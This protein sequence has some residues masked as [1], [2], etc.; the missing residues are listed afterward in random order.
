[1]A[2]TK[3]F[4]SWLKIGIFSLG[5]LLGLS[6]VALV[7][8]RLVTG[9]G[10]G[11]L[12]F[13][14]G[15][16]S[17]LKATLHSQDATQLNHG[18]FTNIVFLHHSTGENLIVQGS[19]RERFTQA[20]YSFWDQGYN[21]AGLRA[22]D[23]ASTGY[24]YSVPN[25]NTDP[26]SLARIFSQ[27]VYNYPINALSGL[28]QHEVI[29]IKSCFAPANNIRS[30]SQLEDFKSWYTGIRHVM[31]QHP[32]KIFVIVTT[33]PLNP[34]ETNPEEASKARAIAE[35]LKSKEFLNGHPN[36]VVFDF[37]DQLAV[38]AP[39]SSEYSMLRPEYRNGADSHPTQTANEK[40]G[41]LFVDF[42]IR[43]IEQYRQ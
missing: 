21:A 34:E 3:R 37:F 30:D 43:A 8:F 5:L 13:G 19:V 18:A 20:G 22:P 35:W 27:Q 14:R 24:G 23:G 31:D 7:A 25:D 33:P 40:I 6:L 36:I 15:V 9:R 12:S 28:L 16:I 42:V 2:I 29:I 4:R 26:D 39:S 41:P 17:S 10:P 38:S 1:M 11:I 32:G